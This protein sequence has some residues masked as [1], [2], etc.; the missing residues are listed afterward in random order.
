MA[1]NPPSFK[2]V[3]WS[4]VL[5]ERWYLNWCG[6]TMK[7]SSHTQQLSANVLHQP[8]STET[9]DEILPF[10]KGKFHQLSDDSYCWVTLE[11][12]G[13][14]SYEFEFCRHCVTHAGKGWVK[15]RKLLSMDFHAEFF[16]GA[17][18][19]EPLTGQRRCHRLIWENSGKRPKERTG[20]H[21]WIA[22]SQFWIKASLKY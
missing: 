4:P 19:R 5:L 14:K 20:E 18:G 17:N 8:A 6:R 22:N 15:M 1:H 13:F 2:C 11:P 16:T 10:F 3:F 7:M 21:F 12:E 9:A